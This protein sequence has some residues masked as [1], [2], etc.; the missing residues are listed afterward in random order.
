M[1]ILAAL[2]IA[3]WRGPTRPWAA[4]GLAVWAAFQVHGLFDWSFGDVE[5]VDQLYLWTGL[6]LGAAMAAGRE[7]SVRVLSDPSPRS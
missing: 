3:R 7:E 4:L 2:L 5:V 1:G 6:A